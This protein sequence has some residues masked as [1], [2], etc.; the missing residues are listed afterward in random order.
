MITILFLADIVGEAGRKVATQTAELYLARG[1]A[2]M[3]IAN[4]ENSAGGHGITPKIAIDLMRSGIAVITTGNH[5]WNKKEIIPY[6]ETEPRLL[7]P[8]NYPEGTPGSGSV[9]LESDKGPV[10]ILNLQGLSFINGML[11]NPFLAAKK[12]VER[13]REITPIIFVDMH[14]ETTSEKM[15]MGHF[16]DGSVSAVIGTHTHVPTGDEQILPQGTAFLCDAGMCGPRNS[17]LGC[18]ISSVL[19]QFTSAVPRRL[20]LADGP[21]RAQGVLVKIDEE[22]GKSL[23]IKRISEEY[24]E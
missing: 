15:A 14:A 22:S 4:G 5:I 12:E 7:R 19:Q 11:D 20:P 16:L 18:D 3:V 9:I 24:G 6:F 23:S 13:L 21:A 8:L 10:A 2:D 17:I 1:E